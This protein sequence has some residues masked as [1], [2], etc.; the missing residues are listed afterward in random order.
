[1]SIM[2]FLQKFN[3]VEKLEI[4]R[5]TEK[6]KPKN[7]YVRIKILAYERVLADKILEGA[8]ENRL[9]KGKNRA[10]VQGIKEK[11]KKRKPRSSWFSIS[12]F[13]ILLLDESGEGFVCFVDVCL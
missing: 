13:W 1:M 11:Y 4:F 10:K 6:N 8:E 12:L 9:S 7:F 3:A 2:Y 5:K